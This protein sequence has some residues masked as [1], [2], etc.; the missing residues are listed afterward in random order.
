[1]AARST[2]AAFAFLLAF[3]SFADGKPPSEIYKE[4]ASAVATLVWSAATEDGMADVSSGSAFFLSERHIVT[5]W[6]VAGNNCARTSICRLEFADGESEDISFGSEVIWSSQEADLVIIQLPPPWG[7]S[8]EM[9]RLT[10]GS[11]RPAYMERAQI[12]LAEDIP[13]VGSPVV[14]IGSPQGLGGTL[15]TGVVSARR[16][17]DGRV[18]QIT[19]QISPGSSGSPVFDEEGRIVAIVTSQIADGQG[20]NFAMT[21]TALPADIPAEGESLTRWSLGVVTAYEDEQ[22]RELY[23]TTRAAILEGLRG[24]IEHNATESPAGWPINRDDL[25]SVTASLED[26]ATDRLS[27]G[28]TRPATGS[29]GRAISFLDDDRHRLMSACWETAGRAREY[30]STDPAIV[31]WIADCTPEIDWLTHARQLLPRDETIAWELSA[32]LN[33]MAHKRVAHKEDDLSD[34]DLSDPEQQRLMA[35][36][37]ERLVAEVPDLAKQSEDILSEL[38]ADNPAWQRV[39]YFWH[40]RAK[41][42]ILRGDIVEAGEH[43][44]RRS[45]CDGGLMFEPANARLSFDFLV[46][47]AVQKPEVRSN[48]ITVHLLVPLHEAA[49]NCDRSQGWSAL[50]LMAL[51]REAREILTGLEEGGAVDLEHARSLVADIERWS[52]P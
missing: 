35:G 22:S 52:K 11:D 46:A 28:A 24:L 33:A 8:P 9:W 29:W 6:H 31:K 14:V 30:G 41:N 40:L 50:N 42:S 5:N 4:N 17:E 34:S 3:T 10:T 25:I 19:A 51:A 18:L 43:L 13:E 26:G 1:M 23:E 21:S 49:K 45:S 44:K 38:L 12:T 15:S 16:G 47:H 37:R 48:S 39:G 27:P 2:Q 36:W 20:L 7:M 32:Q